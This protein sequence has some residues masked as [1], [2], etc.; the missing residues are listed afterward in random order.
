MTK[1][2]PTLTKFREKYMGELEACI[3]VA[4][5][6]RDNPESKDKDRVDAIKTVS[7]L[8]GALAPEKVT[9]KAETVTPRKERELSKEEKEELKRLFNT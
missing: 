1:K 4:I 6:I 7:R 2:N 8:L 9:Q 5:S 3:Q